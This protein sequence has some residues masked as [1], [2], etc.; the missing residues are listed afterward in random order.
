MSQPEQTTIPTEEKKPEI[1]LGQ[2]YVNH[3]AK[4]MEGNLKSIFHTHQLL[5]MKSQYAPNRNS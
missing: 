2:D 3:I 1:S 4:F 5:R